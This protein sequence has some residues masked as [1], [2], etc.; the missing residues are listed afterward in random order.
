M[1]RLFL[2]T[3]VHRLQY[4]QP[5]SSAFV[6]KAAREN[7]TRKQKKSFNFLRVVRGGTCDV[8]L[9]KAAR[10]RVASKPDRRSDAYVQKLRVR[11]RGAP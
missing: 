7:R 4:K 5:S 10:E 11:S 2:L 9:L 1:I 6:V 3:L 8:S